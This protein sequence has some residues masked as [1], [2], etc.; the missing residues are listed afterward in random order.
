MCGQPWGQY[1]N[2]YHNNPYNKTKLNERV[3][4]LLSDA[5]IHNARGIFE[6]VL[7]EEK[8]PELL[9]VRVFDDN[10]KRVVYNEQ[11]AEAKAKGISNCPDCAIGH[12]AT[13]AKI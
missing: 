12:D 5:F 8:H 6:Y 13:A 4:E 11:T 9:D 2:K 1:F 3:N 10:L 7:G